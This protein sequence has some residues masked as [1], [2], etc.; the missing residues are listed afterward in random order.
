MAIEADLARNEPR[1]GSASIGWECPSCGNRGS[2][3][4]ER[5]AGQHVKLRCRRCDTSFPLRRAA[6]R[7]APGARWFVLLGPLTEEE[8]QA[9]LQ[10]GGLGENPLVKRTGESRW[11][12]YQLEPTFA[13]AA[14]TPT[15]GIPPISRRQPR[16][17]EGVTA[18][19]T[20]S[21]DTLLD[22]PPPATLAD[23]A[24]SQRLPTVSTMPAAPAIVGDPPA[25]TV[26]LTTQEFESVVIA[27]DD[28][29]E[30][31]AAKTTAEASGPG[32]FAEASAPEG[33]VQLD[34]PS[35]AL[36]AP[37]PDD[38]EARG[39]A[40]AMT[41]R[42][43]EAAHDP[44]VLE[45]PAL[46]SSESEESVVAPVDVYTDRQASQLVIP[47]GYT[48]SVKSDEFEA[49]VLPMNRRRDRWLLPMVAALALLAGVGLWALLHDSKQSPPPARPGL[50]GLPSRR[51]QPTVVIPPSQHATPEAPK[52]TTLTS[53]T[54]QAKPRDLT[55]DKTSHASG[56]HP[57]RWSRSSHPRTTRRHRGRRFARR[58]HALTTRSLKGLDD[59]GID[60]RDKVPTI[61]HRKLDT[62][63]SKT[64]LAG[65]ILRTN[66]SSLHSCHLLASRRGE[67]IQPQTRVSFALDVAPSGQ[68]RKV[69]V[70]GE[71][72]RQLL[73][74]Y[75]LVAKR[76]SLPASDKPYA[77]KF[78][79]LARR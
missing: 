7:P 24:R 34:A 5:V 3:A 76:W 70:N 40:E 26:R 54:P 9:R 33:G 61:E 48:G 49:D 68:A 53:L 64:S 11:M 47:I 72:P 14:A 10:R 67:T 20:A 58:R 78:T 59:D 1:R 27:L 62:D 15:T 75:R 41:G 17:S 18:N 71:L 29:E 28:L 77:I 45:L 13:V 43:P 55:R 52:D 74:C 19:A 25:E 23:L 2:I 36:K 37:A 46:A 22:P 69:T 66:R 56:S 12:P 57:H 35:A 65:H 38:L 60:P 44:G 42:E 8:L 16:P 50:A 63:G 51:A 30:R 32:L 21:E 6:R 39:D 31:P 4:E 79:F 73:S